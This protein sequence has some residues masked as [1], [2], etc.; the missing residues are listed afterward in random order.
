M[1]SNKVDI[2]KKKK[3]IKL[4][5]KNI[6]ECVSFIQV[7]LALIQIFVHYSIISIIFDLHK[8]ANWIICNKEEQFNLLITFF[9]R[10]V[11]GSC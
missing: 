1:C 10:K 9:L 7:Y 5:N 6:I 2:Q 3:K 8:K 4:Q 11:F